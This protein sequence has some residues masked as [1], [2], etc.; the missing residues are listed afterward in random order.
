MKSSN[1][2]GQAV[3]EGVMMRN[4]DKYAVA[5]RKTDG[6][7]VVKT[8][9]YKG[10][11]RNKKLRS[12]P[13]IRGV[14]SFLD[15][16]VL[17]M[18]TLTYSASFFMEEEEKEEVKAE[19]KESLMMGLTIAF[20]VVMAVAVFMILPY[21]LSQMF[22]KFTDSM[23]VLTLLEGLVRLLIFFGYILLISRMED[24]QRVFMYHGAEHKCINCIEHGMEL[25][26]ENVL[27]SSRLHKRCGTSFLFIVMIVSMIIFL[28]IRIESQIWRL[29]FRLLLIPVIA[30]VSFEFIR[31]AGKSENKIVVML[32][33]PG[34]MLQKLTTREPDASM[35][36][37]AIASVEAVFDWR[38]Y[39]KENFDRPEQRKKTAGD[40]LDG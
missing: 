11:C 4:A 30:G 26:V 33:K 23:T 31:L 5:V 25:N 12:F 21:F 32:S 39:L 17:G 7:I 1:I 28:F 3:I 35:A 6:E 20:S 16:M 19:K 24:I 18:S 40:G 37:V 38:A 14:F 27:K 8:E 22:R 29:L 13:I 2:G 9:E 10:I 15:S 36:E 34:M